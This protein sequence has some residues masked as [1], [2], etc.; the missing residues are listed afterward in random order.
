MS[1][2]PVL[3]LLLLVYSLPALSAQAEKASRLQAWQEDLEVL[4]KGL[5][6][7]HK[8]PFTVISKDAFRQR[9]QELQRRLPSLNEP[10][11][12]VEFLKLTALIGD[13]HTGAGPG[14]GSKPWRRYPIAPL[15][16]KEGLVIVGATAPHQELL[17]AH[18]V[19]IGKFSLEDV[20]TRLQELTGNENSHARKEALRTFVVVPEVLAGAGIV[21]DM[22]R[23][24]FT[25]LTA[26]GQ[27]RTVVLRPLPAN[28]RVQFQVV[29]DP[30]T[31]KLPSSR[32]WQRERYG[33]EWSAEHK[34]L[35]CWYDACMDLPNRPVSAWCA[36]VLKE[37]DEK[38]AA[39]LV[40][41]L[42]RNGGGNS[43]LIEPLFSGLAKR[44]AFRQPGSIIVL[45]SR[46]TYSSAM[47][48]ALQ[49][50]QRFQAVLIGSP[51]G[52]SPNSFGEVRT[53]TLPHCQ[54][55][56][57]YS[58]KLF[59]LTNDKATTVQPD[60]EVEWTAEEFFTGKD[61][62]LQAAWEYRPRTQKD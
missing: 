12:Q 39:R 22:E 23:A 29:P 15:W 41:D 32:Q 20:T 13:G 60:I 35:Y 59:Q 26:E 4:A 8:N 61:P 51:T 30:R 62:V 49:L 25:V 43:V 55:E 2:R 31:T 5:Q 6:E 47:M 40:L 53:F 11:I 50:R 57:R 7:K 33:L 46:N 56:V 48:N 36:E 37:M 45:I 28:V 17:K 3:S 34:G 14:R 58:T 19:G 52:G 18:I 38:K 21:E 27:R 9:V 1:Y 42:R 54:W 24:E 10:Q 16:V 44:P